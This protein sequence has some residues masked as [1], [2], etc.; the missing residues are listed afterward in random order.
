M[1]KGI[2]NAITTYWQI[3]INKKKSFSRFL[4]LLTGAMF[5]TIAFFSLPSITKTTLLNPSKSKQNAFDLQCKVFSI[6]NA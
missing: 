3:V 1:F 5:K 4:P 6:K 2:T